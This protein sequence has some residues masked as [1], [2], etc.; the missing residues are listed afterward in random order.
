[1]KNTLQKVDHD[2]K[3]AKAAEK[4]GRVILALVLRGD[5]MVLHDKQGDFNYERNAAENFHIC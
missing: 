2:R 4:S 5:Q 1:M 3:F